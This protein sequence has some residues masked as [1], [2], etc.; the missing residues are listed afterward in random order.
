ME[1]A[2]NLI[3]EAFIS[4]GCLISKVRFKQVYYKNVL[5]SEYNLLKD[6]NNNFNNINKSNFNLFKPNS[7]TAKSKLIISFFYYIQYANAFRED[8]NNNNNNI[9]NFNINENHFGFRFRKL[10]KIKNIFSN[11]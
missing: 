7:K 5:I 9:I 6:N 2:A 10:S 3:S 1:Q 4:M 8:S 11:Y